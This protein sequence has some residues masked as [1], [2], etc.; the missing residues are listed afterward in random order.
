LTFPDPKADHKP[1]GAW[2]RHID[3]PVSFL[4]RT[5]AELKAARDK[6]CRTVFEGAFW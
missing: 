5:G 2:S 1:V 3:G 4:G 6:A